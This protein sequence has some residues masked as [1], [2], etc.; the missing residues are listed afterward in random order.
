MS[1]DTAKQFE[2]KSPTEQAVK[3]EGRSVSFTITLH[4]NGQIEFSIPQNKILAY[5]LLGAAQEQMTKLSL[6]GEM[7]K[8]KA[9][10]G[11]IGGLMQRMN[12]GK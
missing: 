12:G 4:P 11:G 7:Q 6:M 8:A 2:V 5:G 3:P 9:S 10:R 1:D